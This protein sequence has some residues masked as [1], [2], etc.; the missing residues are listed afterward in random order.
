MSDQRRS[1]IG[2]PFGPRKYTDKQLADALAACQAAV[3]DLPTQAQYVAWAR[4]RVD[5][6]PSHR[7]ITMALG[8]GSWL[9]ALERVRKYRGQS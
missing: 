2:P 9:K 6:R 1:E 5:S 3:G 8:R 4:R 7:L